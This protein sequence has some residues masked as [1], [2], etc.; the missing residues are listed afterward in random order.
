MKQLGIIGGTGVD[1]LA[2]LQIVDSHQPSTPFGDPSRAI[3]EGLLDGC[4]VFF[5]H[6]HGSPA[7]IPPHRV[8]YRANIWA[9]QAL[10]VTEIVAINAVGGIA[11]TMQ[12]GRLVIPDQLIDYTW[13][14]DHTFDDGSSGALQHIDFTE[15]YHRELHMTLVAVASELGI[16]CEETAVHGVT[17]GPR[18]ETAAEIRK[19][20]R[21]GCDVVGMTGMPE[22]ALARELGIAYACVCMVVNPAAGLADEPIS[23]TTMRDILQREAGVVASLLRCLMARRYSG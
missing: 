22:A 14:R 3:Q 17:Q 1:E 20:A 6:R 4:R 15:P 13:G 7:A 5:L 23:L 8:N 10:G 12:P 21:D 2:G 18:L 16:P 11:P 9:L 19:L